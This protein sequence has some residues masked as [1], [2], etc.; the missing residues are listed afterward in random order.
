MFTPSNFT[1]GQPIPAP[2]FQRECYGKSSLD[3][4]IPSFDAVDAT[5]NAALSSPEFWCEHALDL[6]GRV[7][8][9][10]QVVSARRFPL[11]STASK[12]GIRLRSGE[13]P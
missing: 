4:R 13:I 2:T 12:G 5:E 1:L 9:E 11:Q 7:D 6:L 3:N 8:M 10:I